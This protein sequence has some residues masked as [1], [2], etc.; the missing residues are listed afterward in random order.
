MIIDPEAKKYLFKKRNV[1]GV[2]YGFKISRGENTG[3][4]GVVCLV[5]K[6]IDI[7]QLAVG[8]R[9]PTRIDEKPTDVIQTGTIRRQFDPTGRFRP[10]RM[11]ISVGHKAITAGTLG[12]F[13][14][15][16]GEIFILSNNHVLANSNNGQIGDKILQP[17]PY[18]GGS[19]SSDT[20]AFL[21]SFV[22][23]M[24]AEG[25]LPTTCPIANFIKTVLNIMLITIGSK[26]RYNAVRPQ[27]DPP[28]N[29]VDCALAGPLSPDA[30]NKIDQP[31]SVDLS[32]YYLNMQVE[33][34]GRT[35]G[36]TSSYV[37]QQD[38]TV[39]VEYDAGRFAR[40]VDQIG[41]LSND[42]TPFSQGGDSGS[43]ITT[44]AAKTLI[45]LLYAGSDQITIANPIGH[46]FTGLG[47]ENVY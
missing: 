29:L 6:K 40:F 46:V 42:K 30:I 36:A 45:G 18:D 41:I 19:E 27:E 44:N 7:Q 16:Y 25:S 2:G 5:R 47:I 17:G 14:E 37:A 4:K 13:V 23:I 11:G 43:A 34:L 38:L 24:F 20:V 1:I 9:I 26:T 35:T 32:G 15:K 28:E 22:P 39:D 31:T 33:K 12:C 8:D 10:L 21:N 3:E